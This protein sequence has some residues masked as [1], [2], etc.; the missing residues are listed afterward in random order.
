MDTAPPRPAV[1]PHEPDDVLRHIGPGTQLV[2]PLANGEPT[3]VLDAIE[4]AAAGGDPRFDGVRVH[5]MHALHD[6][7]YL[8]GEFL[9][10]LKHIS[11]FLSHVTR[12]YFATDAWGL[13][14]AHFSEVYA[15]MRMR[16][17]DPLVMTIVPA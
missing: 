9:P 14:P 7:R 4:D 1:A 12:P 10:G 6:R 17:S 16:A 13:V 5:Q 8:A 15:R 2:V 11:Y 3:A